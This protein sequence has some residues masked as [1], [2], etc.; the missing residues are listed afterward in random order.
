[1]GAIA[2]TMERLAALHYGIELALEIAR[3]HALDVDRLLDAELCRKRGWSKR[4]DRRER[5]K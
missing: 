4:V 3:A 1:M 2:A 5:A